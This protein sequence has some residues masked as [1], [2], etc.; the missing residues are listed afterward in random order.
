MRNRVLPLLLL[1]FLVSFSVTI[2][3]TP[4]RDFSY[5]ENRP[6]VRIPKPSLSSWRDTTFQTTL[7]SAL[8]D[9][10]PASETLKAIHASIGRFGLGY[11]GGF[12]GLAIKPSETSATK[13]S[14]ITESITPAGGNVF[15]LLPAGTRFPSPLSFFGTDEV[16]K[17]TIEPM[18]AADPDP[19]T[20]L[21][22]IQSSSALIGAMA[23][24]VNNIPVYA[25]YL[26]KIGRAH[27]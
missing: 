3:L 27:V 9:Q 18:V 2:V 7:E 23:S 8:S 13:Y 14:K 4:G 19:A 6:L 5:A 26:E 25:Y 22:S 16:A 20:S 12:M 21:Q 11:T 10:W 17:T 1:L 15:S 24:T